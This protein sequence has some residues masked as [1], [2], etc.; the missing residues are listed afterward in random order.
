M[1]NKLVSII[2]PIYNQEKYLESFIPSLLNQ[3]YS[4]I[5]IIL[6]NDGSTDSSGQ[7][8]DKYN[9][10]DRI[11]VLHKENGGLVS[12]VIAGI[13]I[14]HGD[15]ICFIDPDDNVGNHY[16]ERF[17]IE[18]NKSYDVI[19]MG[20]YKNNNGIITPEYLEKNVDL[21]KNQIEKL[22]ENFLLN[23]Q[24]KVSNT[25]FNSRWNKMYSSKCIKLV[26]EEYK[27]FT[28]ISLGEDTIFTYLVLKYSTSIHVCKKPNSYFYNISNLNSMTHS[29][30]LNSY[31]KKSKITFN[32]F[33][34]MLSKDKLS[35]SQAYG[36][37]Y[38]IIETLIRRYRNSSKKTIEY[39][40]KDSLYKETLKFLF[41][42]VDSLHDKFVLSLKIIN[43]YILFEK[44]LC[45]K[46]LFERFYSFCKKNIKILFHFFTDITKKNFLDSY[47]DTHFYKQRLNAFS[48]LKRRLP[49]LDAQISE[50][51]DG[52][53]FNVDLNSC[54]IVKNIFIF[55]WDGFLNAPVT[56]KKCLL[57]VK[58]NFRD[59]SIIEIS[60]FNYK[61]YT[62][63]DPIIVHDFLMGKISIQTFSDVMRFNLLKNNGGLWID[64]T[65]YFD[66]EYNL[67]SELRD[68]S[69]NTINYEASS[70]FLSYKKEVCSWSSFFVASR[71]N[72]FLVTVIDSILREYYLKY[73]KYPIYFFMDAVYMICKVNRIDNDVLNKITLQEGN[74]YSL[75][76]LLDEEYDADVYDFIMTMPQKLSWR[77]FPSKKSDYSFYDFIFSN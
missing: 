34:K 2:V 39:I 24:L 50:L 45:L 36:L 42:Y 57:S 70:I 19:A 73:K 13:E 11:K 9:P 1:I 65:I 5:E 71:K 6:V 66:K 22:K 30:K 28:D 12:A 26:C 21:V 74:M 76:N 67:L 44:T 41:S 38:F 63:I 17:I 49:V 68:K 64:A 48:D 53:D 8:C 43:G 4:N 69:F 27:K 40:Y 29:S 25:I 62:D 14:A 31:L 59:Y 51:L 32:K 7:I 18:L 77:Y 47:Q 20:Y 61:E 72:G 46:L 10:S 15:Y 52:M 35:L 58:Q 37:Y 3:S 55:W 16:I 56:V 60:K 23:K 33:S 54:P 75:L